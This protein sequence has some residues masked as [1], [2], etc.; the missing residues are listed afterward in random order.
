MGE[1]INDEIL[2][3]FA[4]VADPADIPEQIQDRYSGLADRITLYTPYNSG[5]KDTF[6]HSLITKLKDV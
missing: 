2:G 3:T 1:L 4:V 5:E 6:W